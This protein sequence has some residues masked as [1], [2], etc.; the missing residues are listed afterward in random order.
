MLYQLLATFWQVQQNVRPA[1]VVSFIFLLANAGLNI[2][3]VFGVGSFDGWFVGSPIATSLTRT[4]M[5]LLLWLYTVPFRRLHKKCWAGFTAAA[6]EESIVRAVIL[7]QALPALLAGAL[8]SWQLQCVAFL[9]AR[10]GAV[11]LASHMAMMNFY[12]FSTSIQFGFSAATAVRV[13]YHLG[14]SRVPEAKRAGLV[15]LAFC[16]TAGAA[17]GVSIHAARAYLGR[18]FSGDPAVW[19]EVSTLAP[20]VGGGYAAMSLFYAAGGVLSGQ[21]RPLVVAVAF[22]I[23]AWCVCI[24]LAWAFTVKYNEGLLGLWT[25]LM[26]GYATVTLI[27]GSSALRSDWRAIG[28]RA[29]AT[30]T[31]TSSKPL[32]D[33][34]EEAGYGTSGEASTPLPQSQGYD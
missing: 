24:P 28:G 12:Y 13:G 33:A 16:A 8:E 14:G 32:L 27:T 10:M 19:A 17:V 26:I 5:L 20:L 1:L 25:A 30:A 22:V 23:G 7:R 9:A 34:V 3:L 2:V 21:G 18:L 11:A 31:A 4:G 15:G 6:F 29:V